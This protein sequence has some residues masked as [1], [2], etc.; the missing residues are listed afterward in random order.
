MQWFEADRAVE[1]YKLSFPGGRSRLESREQ[2]RRVAVNLT[3]HLRTSTKHGNMTL[4]HS[5]K[6][7]IALEQ[8]Q[9]I[10]SSFFGNQCCCTNWAA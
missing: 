8:P 7:E 3:H 2:R 1:L 5:C 4:A 9:M 6:F 10:R